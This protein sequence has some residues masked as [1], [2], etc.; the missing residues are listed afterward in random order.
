MATLVL[1]AVGSAI[2]GP[3]GGGIGALIGQQIDSSVLGGRRSREGPR[4]KELEVTTSS[5]GTPIARHFGSVRKAGTIIWSTDLIE[6][7]ET[8]GGKNQP[9]VTTYTYSVSFAVAL[10]SR[11]ILGVGRIWA[12]GNLLR[13]AAGDL[14]TGGALRIYDGHGNHDADPLMASAQGSQTPAY[15]GFAHAVFEDLQL[16]DYGNRIPALTFEIF[17]DEGEVSLIDLLTPIK[18]QPQVERSLTN[19]Q[20]FSDEG[21]TL[22]SNLTALGQVYPFA[23]DASGSAARITSSDVTSGAIPT[24]PPAT[25]AGDADSFGT[26]SGSVHIRD[27][28]GAH[29]P[30]ALRYYDKARDYQAGLQRAEGKA[31]EGRS[32]T[33]ELPAVL[34]AGAARQLI[35][36]SSER[37]RTARETLVWRTAE[38][39]PDLG[40]G[41]IVRVPDKPGLWIVDSWEW[42]EHGVELELT[43]LPHLPVQ[44]STGDPGNALAPPDWAID[45]TWLFA[46][47][48]PWDGSGTPDNPQILAA[49]SA[50]TAGWKGAAL[51]ADADGQ[52]N[53][54]ATADRNRS[55]VGTTVQELP[56]SQSVLLE[57]GSSVLIEL[58]AEDQ[59]LTNTDWAGLSNGQN[60]AVVGGELI[61]FGTAEHVSGKRW[62]ISH[63]LRGRG[64]TETLAIRGHPVGTAFAMVDESAIR[65][66]AADFASR[67]NANIAA[68]GLADDEP[69]YAPLTNGGIATKPLAPVHGSARESAAGGLELCWIRRARGA[70]NWP[71][72]VDAALVEQSESYRVG[73][74]TVAAPDLT[75]DVSDPQLLIDASTHA[76]LQTNH[77]GKPFWVRQI[78]THALSDPL[79]LHTVF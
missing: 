9:K 21:H 68:I 27:A 19:L 18:A 46:F 73:L 15:R 52:L 20:G 38:L 75:W 35:N 60:L 32:I 40:P 74:G 45:P 7:K 34:E 70:W 67:D 4:L 42:R 16:A 69:V 24:L 44:T 51:Y 12:D 56:P 37:A 76:G 79:L 41:K 17:A 71:D 61:Q 43:R 39:D 64:G 72:G 22:A 36:Q 10:S 49:L 58:V 1:T 63:L 77:A 14:K 8:S 62:R 6:G 5:Y 59:A 3:F 54:I 28:G 57:N 53:E 48:L 65:L 11:P 66:D 47:E 2:G 25:A 26:Q 13:G 78:G 30:D 31:K 55:V 50:E 33:I 23:L 29:A